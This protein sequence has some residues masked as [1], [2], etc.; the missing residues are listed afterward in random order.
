MSGLANILVVHGTRSPAGTLLAHEL[1]SAVSERLGQ[2]VELAFADVQSPNV[3]EVL[4]RVNDR[5]RAVVVP[6]LLAAGFHATTDIPQLARHARVPTCITQ[7]L[8]PSPQLATALIKR[9]GQ[10]I[11]KMRPTTV[12]L[13]AVPSSRLSA[14]QDIDTT[15]AYVAKQL[16]EQLGHRVTVQVG[17]IS[18]A[19]DQ[20]DV[21]ECVASADRTRTVMMAHLLAPGLFFDKLVSVATAHGIACSEPLG[22]HD[23]LVN[24]IV[25]KFSTCSS[26]S[27]TCGNRCIPCL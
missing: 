2:P 4:H 12:I 17:Y 21:T 19:E 11:E 20:V 27:T 15:A 7:P 9:A 10:L 13:G 1:S 3:D 18:A 5:T 25:H 8:G 23:E 22:I 16:E 26:D 14:A 6:A 24:A